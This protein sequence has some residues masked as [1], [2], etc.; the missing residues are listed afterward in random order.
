MIID[1][2]CNNNSTIINDNF[3][4]VL[5]LDDDRIVTEESL[6][7]AFSIWKVIVFS[8]NSNYS[9]YSLVALL[10]VCLEIST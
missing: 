10:C 9:C 7:F 4:A 2:D 6:M 3:I 8:N 5:A 1:I